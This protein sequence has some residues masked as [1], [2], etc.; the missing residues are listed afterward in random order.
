MTLWALILTMHVIRNE[1][2]RVVPQENSEINETWI[3]DR[4]RFSY[5]AMYSDARLKKVLFKDNGEWQSRRWTEALKSIAERLRSYAPEDVGILI[6]PNQSN[7]EIYLLQKIAHALNINNID[8]RVQ[9]VDFS[10][11]DNDPL[12]PWLGQNIADIE[13]QEV[14][15]IIGSDLRGEQPMLM[16]RVRKAAMRG[17]KVIVI[18]PQN[19]DFHINLAVNAIVSPQQWLGDLVDLLSKIGDSSKQQVP[20]QLKDLLGSQ[21]SNDQMEQI[22]QMLIAHENTCVLIGNLMQQHFEYAGLRTIAH[23]AAKLTESKFGII[24]LASNA[25]GASLLGALPHRGVM[26]EDLAEPGLNS[27]EMIKSPR[28]VYL[29][30]GLEPE[31]DCALPA[32]TVQ[33]LEQADEVIALTSFSSESAREYCNWMLPIACYAEAEGTKVKYGG[34]LASLQ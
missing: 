5:E 24:S 23:W 22:A 32:A 17:A 26:G 14:I 21:E 33:A 4:D 34:S 31:W 6:S 19:F 11:Q 20:A 30:M 16:Q 7:E 29:L 12:F 27:V 18:N 13:N 10:D 28:K 9:Q 25:V 8:H 15:V 1:V 2:I 3:S